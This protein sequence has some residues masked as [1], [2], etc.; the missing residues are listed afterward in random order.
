ML[1]AILASMVDG[2]PAGLGVSD[3][4]QLSIVSP[5]YGSSESILE[6]VDRVASV[7]VATVGNSFEIILV[8]DGP[9]PEVMYHIRLIENADFGLKVVELSRNFGQAHATWAGLDMAQGERVFLLDC[10]LDEAPEWLSLFDLEMRRSESD[11]VFGEYDGRSRGAAR[12]ASGWLLKT[13]LRLLAGQNLQTYQTSARLMSRRFVDS[14][15]LFREQDPFIGGLSKYVGF[16]HS[17]VRVEKKF[18]S[19]SSYHFWKKVSALVAALTTFTVRPLEMYALLATFFFLVS[20]VFSAF[21]VLSNLW[22]SRPEGWTSLL[23]ILS[24][25]TGSLL[26]GQALIALYVSRLVSEVKQRP[27]YIKSRTLMFGRTTREN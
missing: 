9:Q 12:R 21:L 26:L 14:L 2:G 15:L 10:D 4:V 16:S 7:S 6:F 20:F 5:V 18:N 3:S 27:R 19:P 8:L 1:G 11:L 24:T 13:S 23:V 25:G 22:T 17:A